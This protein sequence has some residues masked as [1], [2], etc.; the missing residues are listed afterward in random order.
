M[1]A[2][3]D[4]TAPKPFA[5]RQSVDEAKNAN[6]AQL[7]QPLGNVAGRNSKNPLTRRIFKIGLWADVGVGLEVLSR[8]ENRENGENP[9]RSRRCNRG[10]T[11]Q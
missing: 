7:T 6:L 1:R 8:P 10:Q 3:D 4:Q 5:A 11:L 2:A 9:L